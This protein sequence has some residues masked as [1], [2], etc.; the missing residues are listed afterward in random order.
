MDSSEYLISEETSLIEAMAKIDKN[1]RKILFVI[2]ENRLVAS[3]T[4]GDIRRWILKGGSLDIPVRQAANNAPKS[5]NIREKELAQAFLREKCIIAAPLVDDDGTVVEVIFASNPPEDIHPKFPCD[6]PVVIQ[7]GGL[8][9]RLYPYTKIL[10]KPLIPIGDIPIT[11]HIING[12]RSYGCKKFY[13]IVNHKKNMIKAYY[14]EIN[15]DYDIVFI[16]EDKP[17]GT[18]G[19]ISLL[20]GLIHST[21]ILTNCDSLIQD[22]YTKIL[23]EHRKKGN[24]ITMVCALKNF[25]IPYGVVEIGENGSIDA[26]REKPHYSFFTN[27]GTYIVEPDIIDMVKPNQPIGFPDIVCNAQQSGWKAGVYP[28]SEKQWLDMGQFDVMEEMRARL[29]V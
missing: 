15:R 4:D 13:M 24:A 5:L 10:P 16:D 14:N 6:V 28:V 7:A 19:G 9:T 18:G 8:G 26:M 2:R 11:E 23:A 12:F 29:G 25:D 21:F 1:P 20:K 17:L 3:V 22:D 27:T